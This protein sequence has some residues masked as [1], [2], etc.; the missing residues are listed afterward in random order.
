MNKGPATKL[1]RWKVANA[2]EEFGI[3]RQTL[4]AKLRQSNAEPAEDGCFSTIQ[5]HR[6]IAGDLEAARIRETNAKA[7]AVEMTNAERM[8]HLLNADMV[9]AALADWAAVITQAIRQSKM[10]HHEK[11]SLLEHIRHTDVTEIARRASKAG[12]VAAQADPDHEDATPTK[13]RRV[14]RK[15]AVAKPGSK[16]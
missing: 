7:D 2:A 3:H 6:A 16:Q 12:R 1:M 14:G 13:R 5:I 10:D 15:K 4:G 9:F 8:G 11:G